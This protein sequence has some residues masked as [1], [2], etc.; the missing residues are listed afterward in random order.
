MLILVQG[1][2]TEPAARGYEMGLMALGLLQKCLVPMYHCL[3]QDSSLL[4][5]SSREE[6]GGH[7]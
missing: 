7:D 1:S 3:V 2:E 6:E 5:I 4:V